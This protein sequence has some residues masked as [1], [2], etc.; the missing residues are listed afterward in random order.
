M[1]VVTLPLDLGRQINK[2]SKPLNHIC[3]QLAAK[4]LGKPGTMVE[5]MV[6]TNAGNIYEVVDRDGDINIRL[7]NGSS[8]YADFFRKVD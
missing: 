4:V 8:Y 3:W 1:V 6:G 7:K 2:M 5:R